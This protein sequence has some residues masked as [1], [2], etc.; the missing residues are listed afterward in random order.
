[1]RT[2]KPIAVDLDGVVVDLLSTM[3]PKLSE[4]AGREITAED[5]S[6]FDIGEALGLTGAAMEEMWDWLEHERAYVRAPSVDGA[7]DGLQDLGRDAVWL[8]TS[9]PESLRGQ[10]IEWLTRHGL[11]GYRLEM[12]VPPEKLTE[13][14]AFHALVEDN[15]AHLDAVASRIELVLLYDQPWNRAAPKRPNIIRVPG[16]AEIVELLKGGC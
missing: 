4:L 11:A 10:T 16:W 13:G 12:G 1:M 3:L 2:D 15:P 7:I 5:I 6:A 8:V 9:R 14:S